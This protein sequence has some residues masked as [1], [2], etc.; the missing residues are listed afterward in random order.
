MDA[1]D[2][3]DDL[4]KGGRGWVGRCALEGGGGWDVVGWGGAQ[5]RSSRL[6]RARGHVRDTEPC[7]WNE[8]PGKL[9]R[10]AYKSAADAA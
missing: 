10:Q 8:E 2:D 3:S 7:E 5:L 9:S 6:N 1:S 4:E